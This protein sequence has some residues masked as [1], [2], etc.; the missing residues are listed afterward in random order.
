LVNVVLA[1]C[2]KRR[3][4][5]SRLGL[6]TWEA[7]IF[8][9]DTNEKKVMKAAMDVPGSIKGFFS[10]DR[11][12]CHPLSASGRTF[13][14]SVPQTRFVV[15]L[16]KTNSCAE[17]CD[18]AGWSEEQAE[19][20]FRCRKW[21]EYRELLK[22][23]DFVD[24]GQ[25]KMEW[26]DFVVDGMRGYKERWQGVCDLCH[27]EYSIPAKVAEQYR[28]DSM[29][30]VFECRL[31]KTPINLQYLKEEFHPS[32]EQVQCAAEAGSRVEPKVERKINE[33]S[34]DTI[35]FMEAEVA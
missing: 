2:F 19:R 15:A 25:I 6:D 5:G 34:T 9:M 4:Y 10:V 32:R 8:F 20:F 24:K 11:L 35:A 13:H 30:M 26:W 7:S 14:F 17:A 31:C 18:A 16:L 23:S 1:Q 3:R 29:K 21:L 12:Y 28:D 33:F 27:E 22:V